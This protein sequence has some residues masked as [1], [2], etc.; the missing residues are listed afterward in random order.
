MTPATISLEFVWQFVKPVLGDRLKEALKKKGPPQIAKQR[1]FNLY[2]TLG[3][4]KAQSFELVNTLRAYSGLVKE[5][6]SERRIDEVEQLVEEKAEK[7]IAAT[8][9]MIDALEALYPQLDIHHHKLYEEIS[10]YRRMNASTFDWYGI[11][12]ALIKAEDGN[13]EELDQILKQEEEKYLRIEKSLEEF[14]IFL[15][16]QFTFENSF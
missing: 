9:E 14:R 5:R 4:V 11:K 12:E 13:P 7:L 1:A 16:N 15:A 2:R 8:S 10:V 6:A 3:Q